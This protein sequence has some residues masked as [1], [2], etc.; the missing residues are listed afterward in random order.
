MDSRF[1]SPAAL[2]F[3]LAGNAVTA[4]LASA[5]S[6]ECLVMFRNTLFDLLNTNGRDSARYNTI[7]IL[8]RDRAR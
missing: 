7:S 4:A 1:F 3:A 6:A 8:S 2:L 5:I